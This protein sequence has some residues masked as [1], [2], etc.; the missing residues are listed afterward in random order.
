MVFKFKIGQLLRPI[1]K[2]NYPLM[3]GMLQVQDGIRQLHWNGTILPL[4]E[5]TDT[6][7]KLYEFWEYE[8]E[9]QYQHDKRMGLLSR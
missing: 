2:D 4:Y 6:A 7:G 9:T 8:L 1:N 5:C 3:V